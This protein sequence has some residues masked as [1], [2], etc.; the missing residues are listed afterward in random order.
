MPTTYTVLRLIQGATTVDLNDAS[1]RMLNHDGFA[2]GPGA[3][4]AVINKSALQDGGEL[5]MA[6]RDLIAYEIVLSQKAA[7]HDALWA[8]V[9]AIQKLLKNARDNQWQRR[10]GWSYT[11]VYFEFA[12][13][14]AT[15]VSRTEVLYGE[16]NPNKNAFGKLLAANRLEGDLLTLWCRPF[17]DKTGA[18]T[19][20]VANT[21]I[22]N[23]LGNAVTVP[24]LLGVEDA[25][26][27]ITLSNLSGSSDDS[28]FVSVRRIGTPANFVGAYEM[29]SAT[30]NV[31]GGW[32]V[33]T[34]TSATEASFS[35]GSSNV[36]IKIVPSTTA[37]QLVATITKSS[38]IIDQ[39]GAFK[40]LARAKA[41]NNT[42]VGLRAR[43]FVQSGSL[44]KQYG[45]Y[46]TY[47]SQ[48]LKASGEIEMLDLT[49][50]SPGLLP[51]IDTRGQAVVKIGIELYAQAS[52]LTGSPELRV[53]Y[54][55]FIPVG[56]GER[57]SA[58]FAKFPVAFN[59]SGV[60]TVI[61][62]SRDNQVEAGV[63][64]TTPTL[65]YT[66]TTK[67]GL[68]ILLPPGGGKVYFDLVTGDNWVHDYTRALDVKVD[69][70]PR[71]PSLVGTT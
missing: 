38:N 32:T 59:A 39:Y 57:G 8:L 54:L 13:T 65:L 37:E 2:P 36:G 41:I 34:I 62:D 6:T 35:P 27:Q 15:N 56:D 10:F 11:P 47:A 58:Y 18:L 42:R 68:P 29:E 9:V 21:S 64:D 70:T 4:Q 12:A 66:W 46:F 67:A 52:A 30:L 44:S 50:T 20:A 48:R 33:A 69:Y 51:A 45:P 43:F 40:V 17:L 3:L 63:F 23:G 53:D 1:S 24:A 61:L 55:R 22:N 26:C 16:W 14:N 31:P 49:P 28:L 25:P 7:N 60:S 71:Y 19:A 5:A